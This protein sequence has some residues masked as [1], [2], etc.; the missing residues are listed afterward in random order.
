MDAND[1]WANSTW[2]QGADAAV[3]EHKDQLVPVMILG[4]VFVIMGL[5][6]KHNPR[7]INKVYNH[8]SSLLS[9]SAPSGC[10]SNVSKAK[11]TMTCGMFPIMIF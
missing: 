11:L 3:N 9:D 7:A 10:A 6:A 2:G 5:V 4:V 8:Y 1:T